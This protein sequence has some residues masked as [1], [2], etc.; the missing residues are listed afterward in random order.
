MITG[1]SVARPERDLHRRQLFFHRLMV[2]FPRGVELGR[3]S[4]REDV[5]RARRYTRNDDSRHDVSA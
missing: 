5:F 4:V 3:H 1:G 2:E